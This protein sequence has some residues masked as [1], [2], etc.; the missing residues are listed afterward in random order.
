MDAGEL[1]ASAGQ[2]AAAD[3]P[4][5]LQRQ[6]RQGLRLAQEL[7]VCAAVRAR[8]YDRSRRCERDPQGRGGHDGYRYERQIYR[9]S[10]HVYL[11]SFGLRLRDC[12]GHDQGHGEG[13]FQDH[14]A[15]AASRPDSDIRSGNP[16]DDSRRRQ[17]QL[18][19]HHQAGCCHRAH[20][21]G[22]KHHDA[23]GG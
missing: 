9:Y 17:K 4:E 5:G 7:R 23:S 2:R 16:R 15:P 22:R 11:R 12:D 20:A 8:A 3:L 10:G 18:H 1:L 19:D 21:Q 14:Y 6:Q 13:R